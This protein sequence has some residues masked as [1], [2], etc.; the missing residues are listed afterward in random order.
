MLRY[1]AVV[2]LVSLSP[3][4]VVP[5]V[6]FTVDPFHVFRERDSLAAGISVFRSERFINPGLMRHRA[7]DGLIVGT[8]MVQNFRPS[9]V[10]S[11]FGGAFLN[12]GMGGSS[13]KEQAAV[14]SAAE[15]L[16]RAPS[17][18]LWGLDMRTWAADPGA[19]IDPS[20]FPTYLYEDDWLGV[21]KNYL[22][23]KD[24]FLLS[25]SAFGRTSIPIDV[26][27]LYRWSTG[28]YVFACE[29]VQRTYQDGALEGASPAV[30]Q[31][32]ATLQ[33]GVTI[34]PIVAAYPQ[35]TF[36]LFIPPYSSAEFFRLGENAPGVLEAL[37][38]FAVALME[39]AVR[40]KNVRLYDFR[41]QWS[42]VTDLDL[43]KDGLHYSPEVNDLMASYMAAHDALPP[44]GQFLLRAAGLMKSNVF[45]QCDK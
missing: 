14:I 42:I 33:V 31:Q 23:S 4:L 7:Y 16:G 17:K 5:A 37:E 40:H 35:T 8:S 32:A 18:I 20:V 44:D 11:A 34:E 6:N 26:D 39:L 19:P 25:W 10:G 38:P 24:I 36:Y 43:F 1:I 2:L 9:Q 27:N 28:G 45:S 29:S 13:L 3:L 22:L 15:E 41:T 21:A 30:L 12:V